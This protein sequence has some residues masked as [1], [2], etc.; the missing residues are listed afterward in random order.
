M[1]GPLEPPD[2]SPDLLACCRGKGGGRRLHVML[3][4]GS[5]LKGTMEERP[6]VRALR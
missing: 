3:A 4:Y 6:G 1:A 2:V 5:G